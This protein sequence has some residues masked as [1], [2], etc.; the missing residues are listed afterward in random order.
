VLVAAS[1]KINGCKKNSSTFSLIYD[2]SENGYLSSYSY[3]RFSYIF[4]S[5]V[6]ND[7][8]APGNLIFIPE[9]REALNNWNFKE[10]KV[11][12]EV[13]TADMQRDD[14]WAYINQDS[15]LKNHKGEYA[16]RGGAKM[17]WHHQLDFKFVQDYKFR[18]GGTEH[19]LQFAVDIENLPN[20]IK[21]S[22][23]NYK[24]IIGNT[25]LSYSNGQYTYNTFNG[26]R[27]TKTY[28]NYSGNV[29]RTL[30]L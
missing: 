17:P 16:E 27:H 23:G 2:G 25:L 12:G 8:S 1:Y 30:Y 6:N 15:Y 3:S 21:S 24:Q 11:N 19:G 29:Q 5:V 20:M 9:S 13:Y 14:F 10:G 18:V 22:W 28:Q 7:Y 26:E 4:S